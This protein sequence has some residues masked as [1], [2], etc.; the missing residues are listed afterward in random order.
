MA[1]PAYNQQAVLD[2]DITR[3]I[4]ADSLEKQGVSFVL[5]MSYRVN[6]LEVRGGFGTLAQF[7]T[8]LNAGRDATLPAYGYGPPLAATLQVTNFGHVQILSV[9]QL[10]GFTGTLGGQYLTNLFAL[11]VYDVTTGRRSEHVFRQQTQ[12]TSNLPAA[13]LPSAGQPQWLE[14]NPLSVPCFTQLSDLQYVCIP[15]Q[16]VWF[17]RPI[18]VYAVDQRLQTVPGA[19]Q[20]GDSAW[21]E[22]LVPVDGV[23][24]GAGVV[25]F[26]AATF[27]PPQCLC[28]F[29]NRMVYA[30]GRKLF[31]SDADRPDN[32][33]ANSFFA[34]PTEMPIT[35]IASVKGVILAF[36]ENETWLYQ[37]SNPTQTGLISGGVVYNLSRSRGCLSPQSF[38]LMGDTVVFMDR[39]GIYTTDGGTAITKISESIDTWFTLPEQIQNPLTNYLTQLGG[40]PATGAQPRAFIDFQDQ[41]WRSTFTWDPLNQF[42]YVTFDDLTLCFSPDF[43]WSVWLYET[44][45]VPL[46]G[47]V[48]KVGLQQRIVNPIILC[49]NGDTY[50]IGGSDQQAYSPAP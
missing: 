9:H 48:P 32:I 21:V 50:M 25:Y 45:A 11:S 34:I 35:A 2:A 36:T 14:R 26:N 30:S 29:Q 41:L 17:Y 49:N 6:R 23:F 47:G 22:T 18:D 16:G 39:R 15:Q 28:A 33:A 4:D 46:V 38:T 27:P 7:G 42:L 40:S 44:T 10:Q 1:N 3:G 37:P 13:A 24:A 12:W 31:F 5:N 20:N 19:L 43:G 8:T